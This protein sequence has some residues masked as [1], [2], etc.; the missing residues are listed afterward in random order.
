[1]TRRLLASVTALALFAGSQAL[2]QSVSVEISPEQR[3][4]IKQYVVE[5]RVKPVRVEQRIA[6]G[7]TLPA[8]IELSP[9]PPAWGPP[10]ARYRYVYTDEQV[11]LVDPSSRRVVEII[12]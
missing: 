12:D 11:V 7:A 9:V 2:A 1:M 4:K 5:E 3:T 8:E 10:F 6:V